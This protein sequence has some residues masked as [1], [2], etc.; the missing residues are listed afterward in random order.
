VLQDA[1]DRLVGEGRW[2]PRVGLGTFAARFPHPDDPGD[3]GWHLDLSFPGDDR[4]P[5]E[6]REFLA[7]RVN[8]T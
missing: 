8:V 4:D 2:A 7:W 5:N 3:A 6:Q 1:F